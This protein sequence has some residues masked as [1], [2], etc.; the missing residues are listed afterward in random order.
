MKQAGTSSLPWT[1]TKPTQE[2]ATPIQTQPNLE[3]VTREECLVRDNPDH[4]NDE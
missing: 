3:L 2:E 1:T 4:E